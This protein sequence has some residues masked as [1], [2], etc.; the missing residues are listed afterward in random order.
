MIFIPGKE[1]YDFESGLVILI[2]KPY[3]WTSFDVV[4]KIRYLIKHQYHLKK[5]KVGHAGTLD[6]L[7]TGLLVICTGKFT[8]MI[9]RF[10]AQNKEYIALFKLGAT[11]PSFDRETHEDQIFDTKYISK[12]QLEQVLNGFIGE[13]NQV[14]PVFSAKQVDGK[15]AYDA[16]RK[17]NEVELKPVIIEIQE[18]ELLEFSDMMATVR[19]KCSK[20]TYIRAIARDLGHRLGSGAYLYDLKRTL[21]GDFSVNNALDVL[22]F[23]KIIKNLQPI[24]K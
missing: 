1:H 2:D 12:E 7:A 10:Q 6:P 3:E 23:E 14:P 17:G 11:T 5:I 9:E 21:S 15:R 16:A 20:G 8:K 18:M 24:T 13:Q 19:I 4:N 22:E